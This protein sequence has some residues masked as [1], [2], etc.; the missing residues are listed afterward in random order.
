MGGHLLTSFT[1]VRF[2]RDAIALSRGGRG[3]TSGHE[4]GS[5]K[6][7]PT[8]ASAA[9]DSDVHD[10]YAYDPDV[11]D[12]AALDGGAL[13]TCLP[14]SA[15][16]WEALH[17]AFRACLTL[18]SDLDFPAFFFSDYFPY[19]VL[20]LYMLYFVASS[21]IRYLPRWQTH[22]SSANGK[23]QAVSQGR[24]HLPGLG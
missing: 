9:L 6:L 23:L 3:S 19:A 22:N 20:M 15:A 7:G 4:H 14:A 11:P 12:W 2:V 10:D 18:A 17:G 16:L 1:L 24:E 21:L 8:G 5:G 13:S